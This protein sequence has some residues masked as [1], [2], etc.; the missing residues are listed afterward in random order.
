MWKMLFVDV[1]EPFMHLGL[2]YP[3]AI[4]QRSLRRYSQLSEAGTPLHLLVIPLHEICSNQPAV[5]YP[6]L[7]LTLRFVDGC[8]KTLY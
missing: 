2:I 4:G 6:R 3:N 5:R 7:I 8:L 1:C